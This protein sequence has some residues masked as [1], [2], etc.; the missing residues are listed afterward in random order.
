MVRAERM[1]ILNEIRRNPIF[2]SLKEA[3]LRIRQRETT[4]STSLPYIQ[5]WDTFWKQNTSKY[6]QK[7]QQWE[8]EAVLRHLVSRT[9]HSDAK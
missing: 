6:H 9:T 2:N 3:N 5:W 1:T 4:N 7:K 8:E